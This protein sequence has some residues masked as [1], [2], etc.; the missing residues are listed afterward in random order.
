LKQKPE[1]LLAPSPPWTKSELAS[2]IFIIYHMGEG[3]WK[4]ILLENPSNQLEKRSP[5]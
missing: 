4:N 5:E 1:E 2:L 3:D